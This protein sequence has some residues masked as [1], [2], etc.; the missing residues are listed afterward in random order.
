MNKIGI[1]FGT[2]TG[3]TRL[4]AKTIWKKLGEDKAAKPLNVN[5]ISVDDMLQHR[6]IILGT[7]TYGQGQLPGLSSGR[8]TPSWLEFLP[9]FK[10]R[11]L[12]SKVFALYGL[13]DQARNPLSFVNG[14]RI[15]YDQLIERGATIVGEWDAA[16]YEFKTS[17]SIVD[18]KFVGLVVDQINQRLLTEQRIDAWLKLI[19]PRLAASE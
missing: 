16:G 17:S 5:R 10:G 9:S 1:F 7:P 12:S 3:S 18:G 2:D 6:Y 4:I 19:V 13:G 15:L 8:L 11:D 14:M